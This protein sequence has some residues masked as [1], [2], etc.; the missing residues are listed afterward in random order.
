MRIC[1]SAG[2]KC[3]RRTQF[4]KKAS[5]SL[6]RRQNGL[7]PLRSAASGTAPHPRPRSSFTEPNPLRWASSRGRGGVFEILAGV[8]VNIPQLLTWCWHSTRFLFSA[9]RKPVEPE[10]NAEGAVVGLAS[11]GTARRARSSGG[12]PFYVWSDPYERRKCAAGLRGA[13]NGAW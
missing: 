9:K 5:Q 10:R 1:Q 2:S 12:L 3:S 13:G 7:A 11:S 8:L 4:V 6:R